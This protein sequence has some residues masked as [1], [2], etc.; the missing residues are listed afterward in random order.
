MK[1]THFGLKVK[2]QKPSVSSNCVN[3][4][5]KVTLKTAFLLKTMLIKVMRDYSSECVKSEC[6]TYELDASLV[7]DGSSVTME[8]DLRLSQWQHRT[9]T[10]DVSFIM[11]KC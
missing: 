9:N 11:C 7:Q 1:I 3:V 10:W 8:F 2:I 5:M 6:V 4:I